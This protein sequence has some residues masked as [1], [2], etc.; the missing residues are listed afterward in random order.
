[1]YMF[2][3]LLQTDMG[4]TQIVLYELVVLTMGILSVI[5]FIRRMKGGRYL[6]K[7]WQYPNVIESHKKSLQKRG[8]PLDFASLLSTHYKSNNEENSTESEIL[9][10]KARKLYEEAF[11]ADFTSTKSLGCLMEYTEAKRPLTYDEVATINRIHDSYCM[12]DPIVG[13]PAPQFP[14]DPTNFKAPDWLEKMEN[15]V[16]LGLFLF[17]AN[18]QI[19]QEE[20]SA[21]LV[22]I[23]STV[24]DH[25]YQVPLAKVY[26]FA[27]D[28]NKSLLELLFGHLMNAVSEGKLS[29]ASGLMAAESIVKM[30]S[31]F[32]AF[33][34][35]FVQ[36]IEVI[37]ALPQ[38]SEALIRAGYDPERIRKATLIAEISDE[39]AKNLAQ[40]YIGYDYATKEETTKLTKGL[41]ILN[42]LEQISRWQ[43]EVQAKFDDLYYVLPSAY[44]LRV[45][46][47][48]T[49]ETRRRMCVTMMRILLALQNNNDWK[50]A[51]ALDGASF[52]PYT[53]SNF[54]LEVNEQIVSVRAF[55]PDFFRKSE[56]TLYRPITLTVQTHNLFSNNP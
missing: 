11:D 48:L 29:A 17:H 42:R 49:L 36:Q 28:A 47:Y 43:G 50:L 40:V 25:Y 2:Y 9:V 45:R 4:T 30:R 52:D 7:G 44:A 12:L 54:E 16:R 38:S 24:L 1:M 55:C 5:L 26:R 23:I 39:K 19:H 41:D 22:A 32:E 8:M 13:L 37:L 51:I 14:I 46:Q 27:N 53:G 56:G 10:Q 31:P 3:W 6:A 20:K 33:P 35:A 21:H 34:A 18:N 15:L